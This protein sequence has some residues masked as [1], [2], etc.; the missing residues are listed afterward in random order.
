MDNHQT[1]ALTA[2]LM[3]LY[4]SHDSLIEAVEYIE[5]QAPI[6]PN[7]VFALLM[8]YHNTLIQE[9]TREESH[10]RPKGTPSLVRV[11]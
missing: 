10:A 2:C 1:Q 3:S 6:Q 11:K 8:R 4:P 9:I 5:A 7:E